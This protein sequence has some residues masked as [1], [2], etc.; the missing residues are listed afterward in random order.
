MSC[1]PEPS[2][3]RAWRQSARGQRAHSAGPARRLLLA[4]AA[5]AA[6]RQSGESGVLGSAPPPTFALRWGDWCFSGSSG[7]GNMLSSGRAPT[8]AVCQARCAAAELC[9]AFAFQGQNAHGAP[10][11]FQC[12]LFAQAVRSGPA[13][14][15][16]GW[17]NHTVCGIKRSAACAPP[18]AAGAGKNLDGAGPPSS[19]RNA[20][21]CAA[22]C[23]ATSGCK[24]WVFTSFQPDPTGEPTCSKA[25][26]FS[27]SAHACR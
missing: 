5:G 1:P 26:T 14:P 17:G 21:E 4:L 8:A 9:T 25:K 15:A 13:N 24:G 16:E 10:D 27:I 23:C 3:D 19:V 22:T 20:T 2:G 12:Y 11:Q 18:S 6:P 7:H